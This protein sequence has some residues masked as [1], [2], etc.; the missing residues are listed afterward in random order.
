M[1]RRPG[2]RRTFDLVQ[3][4]RRRA[5]IAI[6]S[7]LTVFYFLAFAFLW[8]FVK[9]FFFAYAGAIFRAR[10]VTPRDLLV[11]LAVAL[12][13][14]LAHWFESV[15]GGAGR[16][17]DALGAAAPDPRDRYHRALGDIIEEMKTASGAIEVRA[18]VIPALEMNAFS[19]TG[20]DGRSV[21]G[22]TEGLVS[23][24]SRRQLQAVVAHEMGHIREGDNLIVT[25]SCSLFAVFAQMLA[26]ARSAAETTQGR[27]GLLLPVLWAVTVGARLLNVLVSRQREYLADATAVELLRDPIS[28]AEALC[29]IGRRPAGESFAREELAPIFVVN[30]VDSRLDESEGWLATLFSTHPPLGKRIGILLAMAH[31]SLAEIEARLEA[32]DRAGRTRPPSSSGAAAPRAGGREPL[33]I[34]HHEGDWRGPFAAT[35]LLA[36]PWFAPEL[37]VAMVGSKEISPAREVIPLLTAGGRGASGKGEHPCPACGLPLVEREYEGITA[38]ACPACRGLLLGRGQDYRV[39]LREEETFTPEVQRLAEEFQTRHFLRPRPGKAAGKAP[40]PYACPECRRP[41]R[42]QLYNYQYF[43]EVDRCAS[44]GLTWFDGGELEILQV[45]VENARRRAEETH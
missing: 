37:M 36:L 22:V 13:A 23:R 2:P 32:E 3:K 19:V 45:L 14:A 9:L 18:V 4:S 8:L 28:L 6:F 1:K 5:S 21:I 15:A 26:G 25:M 39:M 17:I 41:M 24:L 35:E 38:R 27:L 30:P 12:T 29:R 34:A 40:N 43:L 20:L 7:L 11:V 33:W 42:R 44:C 31:A 16:I 10:L